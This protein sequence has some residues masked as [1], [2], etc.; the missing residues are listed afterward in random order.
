MDLIFHPLAA[1]DVREIGANYARISAN[2]AEKFWGDLDA[3]IALIA[4]YPGR[5]HDDLSGLRRANLKGFPYHILFENRLDCLHVI[6]VRHHHRNPS[7]GLRR[8]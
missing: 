5:H 4:T 7:F 8:R 3:A 1:Q 6:V 2:L